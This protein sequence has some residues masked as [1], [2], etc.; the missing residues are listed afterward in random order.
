MT[1]FY[2]KS[3]ISNL[4]SLCAGQPTLSLPCRTAPGLVRALTI[5]CRRR[6]G[7]SSLLFFCLGHLSHALAATNS[8]DADE[9]PPLAPPRPE[10]PPGFWEQYGLWVGIV[11][12]ALLAVAA[13]L[14]WRL[15][16]PRP[17]VL[18]PI[19][20]LTRE[21]LLGLR[22]RP[23]NGAL[24]S[25][26][27]QTLRHYVAGV[28]SLPADEMTTTEFCQALARHEKIGSSLSSALAQFLRRCDELKFSPAVPKTPMGAAAQA[29]NLVDLAEAR[30]EQLR[31][32][33]ENQRQRDAGARGAELS[34]EQA[35][36]SKSE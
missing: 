29:L 22:E 34:K 1:N 27:S 23:E 30:R 7:L 35:E 4:Q 19:E 26:V 32:A 11:G 24:L 31:V 36:V 3:Q 17:P 9:I 20:V 21:T 2:L 13:F 15:S 14:I 6:S 5:Q 16:R 33:E 18:V 25:Q 8:S 10:I 12:G 28:F